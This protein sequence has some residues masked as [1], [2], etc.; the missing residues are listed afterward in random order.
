M[1][2]KSSCTRLCQDKYGYA[3]TANLPASRW[4]Q[5]SFLCLFPRG[6]KLPPI[7]RIWVLLMSR[8]T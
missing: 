4:K 3:I 5:N 6:I 8:W 1:R 7:S 2:P